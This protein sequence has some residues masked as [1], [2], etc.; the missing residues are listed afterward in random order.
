MRSVGRV[1][2]DLIQGERAPA[3]N[4][5]TDDPGCDVLVSKRDDQRL[6]VLGAVERLAVV[7]VDALKLR[8]VGVPRHQDTDLAC[9]RGG[10]CAVSPIVD[11]HPVQTEWLAQIDLPPRI[12]FTARCV[13][14]K[15]AVLNSVTAASSILCGRDFT[16][17]CQR[18]FWR[19]GFSRDK[20]LV[21]FNPV[22][23]DEPSH[24]H[25]DIGRL[26]ELTGRLLSGG[27]TP[28]SSNMVDCCD[29]PTA[30]EN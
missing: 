17:F 28:V 27:A 24:R 20:P 4:V 1:N 22:R 16:L 15:T 18:T 19:E 6:S 5:Q 9:A 2:F 12:A 13:E 14:P 29:A 3:G 23:F 30:D 8:V 10:C 7:F 21:A 26:H 11:E 25:A